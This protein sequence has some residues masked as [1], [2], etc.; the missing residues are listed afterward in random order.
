MERI[1]IAVA[2]SPV[3]FQLFIK[4]ASR[5]GRESPSPSSN[6]TGGFP[7]SGFPLDFTKW[8]TQDASK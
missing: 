4:L 5:V 6:R 2:M 7:A 1:I 3:N 8:H